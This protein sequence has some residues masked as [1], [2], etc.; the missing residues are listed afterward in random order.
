MKITF[1]GAVNSVTGSCFLVET[2]NSKFIVDCGLF[3]G[4]NI[5]EKHNSEDFY[6][7]INE[8]D[9]VIL[10]HSHIDHSGRIPKLYKDGYRGRIITT[11]ATAELCEIMLPDS[12]YIQESEA[13]WNNRKR[14]RAGKKPVPAIYTAEDAINCLSLFEKR[15]YYETIILNDEVRI[16]F[17]D[18]GHVLGSAILEVWI[19]EGNIETK[20][21]FSGDLGNK[22]M[23]I[24]KDPDIIEE[25]D[26]LI[27]ESTY[28]DRLHKQS[29]AYVKDIINTIIETI[30]KGGNVIIPS[31]AVGRTQ[32]LIY[33]L[34]KHIGQFSY[35][36]NR[37]L[38][39]PVYVDSPLAISATAV[40]RNNLDCCDEEAREYIANGDN[41]LDFP[42]L[43]FSKTADD[44]KALNNLKA[45]AII[46]SASG[47][48]EAGRIK[49]HLK[50]NLWRPES[51]VI[52]VGYQAP[53]TLGRRIA[54]GAK[55]VKIFGEEIIVRA[56]IQ[57]F[58]GFSGHADMNGLLDWLSS[59]KQGPKKVFL[60]HGEMKSIENLKTEIEEKLKFETIAPKLQEE[61]ILAGRIK[62]KGKVVP[63]S[64][65][66]TKEKHQ[67]NKL[68]RE[69]LAEKIEKL[70]TEFE[71]VSTALLQEVYKGSD[72]KELDILEDRLN[73]INSA[74]KEIAG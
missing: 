10:T 11:K 41:P 46:I 16:R 49:H 9:F 17:N 45:S 30:D 44:S 43:Q 3:Q 68:K 51:K 12:G 29:I 56:K 24:V 6:F 71:A 7:N 27:M 66:E 14:T 19:R 1:L 67:D 22:G 20:L 57:V 28:G 13:E 53:G 8:L 72:P 40:Y 2:R 55:K 70:H 15:R 35:E 21:V 52:F 39:I 4:Y 64:H 65:D 42:G 69:I 61:F 54:D 48:C 63:Q 32:E 73:K 62:S 38:D 37:I 18:A 5:D 47:M 34:N 60:V 36:L 33:E 31:F 25:A 26:Y 58:D 50:H 23:P 74:L 59:F